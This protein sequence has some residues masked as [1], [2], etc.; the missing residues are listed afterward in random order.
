M[1]QYIIFTI[2]VLSIQLIS[3]TKNISPVDADSADKIDE[4][5][6]YTVPFETALNSLDIFMRE[7]GLISD[8][9][10]SINHLIDNYF[11]VKNSLT[12]SIGTQTDLLY[13]VNFV[14]EGGYALLSADSRIGEDIL[15]VVEK[16]TVHENDFVLSDYNLFK[17]RK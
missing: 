11:I 4:S 13:A 3:C 9:K 1:K 6:S 2:V 12:K 14:D 8:T 17:F 7:Q 10:G 16:G 5:I 15:A